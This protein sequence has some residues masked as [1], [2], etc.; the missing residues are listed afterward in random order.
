MGM[1]REK[2]GD[3]DDDDPFKSKEMINLNEL[4]S[5]ISNDCCA[6]QYIDADNYVPFCDSLI[7]IEDSNWR[8]VLRTELLNETNSSGKHL[9]LE[10]LDNDKGAFKQKGNDFDVPLKEPEIKTTASA[11]TV[12]ENLLDFAYFTGNDEL[13]QECH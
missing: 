13:S 9:N 10:D 7:N 2:L 3:D 4:S 5:I 6:E 1:Y 12:A 11:A 8:V